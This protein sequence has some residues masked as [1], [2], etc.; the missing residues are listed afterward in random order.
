M[1]EEADV[2]ESRGGTRGFSAEE[3]RLKSVYVCVRRKYLDEGEGR[4]ET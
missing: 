1:G 4:T 2:Q 3:G